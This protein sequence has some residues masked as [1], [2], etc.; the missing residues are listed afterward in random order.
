[1]L[2]AAV[3]RKVI[4]S[5][6]SFLG[7][8]HPCMERSRISCAQLGTIR[9]V[10]SMMVMMIMRTAALSTRRQQRRLLSLILP[11]RGL[12]NRPGTILFEW[13]ISAL[14][15]RNTRYRCLFRVLRL[16]PALLPALL[17][18]QP[19]AALGGFAAALSRWADLFGALRGEAAV[20]QITGVTRL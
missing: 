3:R 7:W 20:G 6:C 12:T 11:R 9:S 4:S 16:E 1:M 8:C 19:R 14:K 5:K 2:S 17:S 18:P 10:C 13:N 15:G